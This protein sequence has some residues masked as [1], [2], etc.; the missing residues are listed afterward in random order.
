L[1]R[2]ATASSSTYAQHLWILKDIVAVDN[3]NL[4]NVIMP[5][6][7]NWYYW[8]DLQINESYE[9]VTRVNF[10][11]KWS[12]GFRWID[13]PE[14]VFM[15]SKTWIWHVQEPWREINVVRILWQDFWDTVDASNA[16]LAY[17][18]NKD[19]LLAT[20]DTTWNWVN[21]TIIWRAKIEVIDE[22]WEALAWWAVWK[23]DLWSNIVLMPDGLKMYWGDDNGSVYQLFAWTD[24]AGSNITSNFEQEIRLWG[25]N[26]LH[27]LEQLIMKWFFSN[28]WDVDI[29][30]DI[31]W[32]DWTKTSNKKQLTVTMPW[33]WNSIETR[34]FKEVKIPNLQR[35]IIRMVSADQKAH[36]FTYIQLATQSKGL[37][38]KS[39][40]LTTV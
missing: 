37:N 12:W 38:T 1:P 17:D 32:K 27:D 14:W 9:Q 35:I 24:D 28:G 34:I 31:Y 8:F 3:P 6:H 15:I 20:V 21:D 4:W 23:Y 33:A 22:R 40:N 18:N 19:M 10:D 16:D 29:N 2:N 36:K 30:I 5:I 25:V 11:I 13:T 39:Q 26:Q 7:E